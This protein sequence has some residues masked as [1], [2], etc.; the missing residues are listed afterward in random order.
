LRTLLWIFK[1][2]KPLAFSERQ[3]SIFFIG[4]MLVGF[5]VI[6]EFVETAK[7]IAPALRCPGSRSNGGFFFITDL[8]DDFGHHSQTA[9][10]NLRI[11][12][13]ENQPLGPVAKGAAG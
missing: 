10:R 1:D 13:D 7:N 2:Y 8:R 12:A 11:V 3:A 9:P 4:G 6:S 5:P